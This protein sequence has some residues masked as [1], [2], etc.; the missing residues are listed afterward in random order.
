MTAHPKPR[1]S[2]TQSFE[3][4]VFSRKQFHGGTARQK[5]V[6]YM[7]EFGGSERGP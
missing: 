1:I 5:T 6:V 7:E 2:C 4:E 3:S